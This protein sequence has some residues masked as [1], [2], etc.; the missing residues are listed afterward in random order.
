MNPPAEYYLAVKYMS[1]IAASKP[2]S[3]PIAVPTVIIN[4][5]QSH[6]LNP[7]LFN[8]HVLLFLILFLD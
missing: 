7:A 3:P 8:F 2:K 1:T 6:F 5:Q 4:I